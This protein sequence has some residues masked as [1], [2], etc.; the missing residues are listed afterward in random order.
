MAG[1]AGMPTRC[2]SSLLLRLRANVEHAVPAYERV[3][4]LALQ[5]AVH[6]LLCLFHGDVH[7][8]VQ[9]CEGSTV[10]RSIVKLNDHRPPQHLLNEVT[11]R[12]LGRHG[13]TTRVR[14]RLASESPPKRPLPPR[15][16]RKPLR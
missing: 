15:R 5:L 12:L 9:T 2:P 4:V 16:S 10:V 13:E 7:V 3:P 8:A 14:P 11:G 6:I 1:G